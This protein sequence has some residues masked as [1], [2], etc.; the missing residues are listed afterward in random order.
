MGTE[1][2]QGAEWNEGGAGGK[3]VCGGEGVGKGRGDVK[4]GV[5][6]VLLEEEGGRRWR[7]SVLRGGPEA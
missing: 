6:G 3:G 1:G 7:R 4:G 2:G 5:G